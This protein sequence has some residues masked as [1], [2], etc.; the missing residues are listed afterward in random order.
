MTVVYGPI[1]IATAM[2]LV[3]HLTNMRRPVAL[4]ERAMA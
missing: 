1:T 3:R 4:P 2:M